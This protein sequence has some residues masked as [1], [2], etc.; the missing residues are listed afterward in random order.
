[1]TTEAYDTAWYRQARALSVGSGC[2]TARMVKAGSPTSTLP[3]KSKYLSTAISTLLGRRPGPRSASSSSSSMTGS[4]IAT[5]KTGKASS[6]NRES[7]TA[8]G[9][10][11]VGSLERTHGKEGL[12]YPESVF[13]ERADASAD[14]IKRV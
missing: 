2:M 1:M 10:G 14:V 12:A 9:G 13:K 6:C 8:K 4:V 5:G 3:I 7:K 11:L